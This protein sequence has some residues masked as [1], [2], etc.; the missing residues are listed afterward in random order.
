M[1]DRSIR[2]LFRLLV[3]AVLCLAV[4]AMGLPQASPPQAAGRGLAPVKF[5]ERLAIPGTNELQ[6]IIELA[7]PPVVQAMASLFPGGAATAAAGGV[8]S[9]DLAPRKRWRTGRNHAAQGS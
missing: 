6:L 5:L 7:D 3:P 8:R 9:L 2:F 4:F 1:R